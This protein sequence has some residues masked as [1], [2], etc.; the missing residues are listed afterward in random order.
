MS[1]RRAARTLRTDLSSF[2]YQCIINLPLPLSW[3]VSS[4]TAFNHGS[5]EF[6]DALKNAY[7]LVQ[8]K[9][10]RTYVD[11]LAYP[12]G[13]SL[14]S[15]DI[16]G[17]AEAWGEGGS[18]R[19]RTIAVGIRE[20]PQETYFLY[21][22]RISSSGTLKISSKR[23][24]D[25]PDEISSIGVSQCG[26][27]IAVTR[28][29]LET[30]VYEE[31][32]PGMWKSVSTTIRIR[33]TVTACPLRSGAGVL[34]GTHRGAVVSISISD[35][36]EKWTTTVDGKTQ[37]LRER[38]DGYVEVVHKNGIALMKRGKLYHTGAPWMRGTIRMWGNHS[39]RCW[40][41]KDLVLVA[42]TRTRE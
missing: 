41:E 31:K 3:R 9:T 15:L 27:S 7:V 22:L 32:E 2:E 23:R 19:N 35:G 30:K 4:E 6:L 18:G 10:R 11:M 34:V 42:G 1:D 21:V 12:T 39:E 40:V 16:K 17:Y 33:G 13:E 8:P 36:R 29:Y 38:S 37:E 20:G 14:Q 28:K 5:R 24:L 25:G 26:E